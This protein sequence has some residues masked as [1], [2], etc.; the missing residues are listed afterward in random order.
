MRRIIAGLF[1]SIDGV[2]DTPNKW[3]TPYFNEEIGQTIGASMAQADALLLAT[4]TYQEFAAYWPHQSGNPI[5]P[6]MNNKPKYIV[7][8][9][10]K[11]LEWQNSTLIRGDDWVAEVT[12]LKGRPGKNILVPGSPA[13]VRSLIRARLL[14]QLNVIMC[15]V[16]VG[17]GARLFYDIDPM[18]TFKVMDAKTISTGAVRLAFEPV[19][20]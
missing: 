20:K 3:N 5:A 2:V 8:N 7:S 12:K 6:L 15:P 14:D 18:T 17:T 11:T 16:V 13:L 1:T 4:K 10:L 9:S 19:N